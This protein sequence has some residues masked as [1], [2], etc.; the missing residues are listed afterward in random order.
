MVEH[1]K[2]IFDTDIGGDCDDVV[3]LDLLISAHQ[4]G[5]CDFLGVSCNSAVSEGAG[6]ARSVLKYRGMGNLPLSALPGWKT[7]DNCYGVIVSRTFPELSRMD[8]PFPAPLNML[9]KLVAENPGVALVS[10]GNLI[11]M[12]AL[13][14]SGP[15]EYSPLN[16]VELC[17]R[18]VSAFYVM[19]GCFVPE[20]EATGNP[21][22]RDT[23]FAECNIKQDV[24]ASVSFFKLAPCP[25]YLLPWE[26]GD[27]VISGKVLVKQGEN[28]PDGLSIIARGDLNGRSSWD[29]MTAMVAVWGH[30][31]WMRLSPAGHVTVDEEGVTWYQEKAD[32]QHYILYLDRAEEEIGQFIDQ[33]IAKIL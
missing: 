30:A 31:P 33:E 25:V 28:C 12:A 29:P 18:N 10:V 32:G 23:P 8:V 17:K 22:L 14:E 24:P 26:A 9:R 3:A 20:K 4:Q 5:L 6:C 2:I 7:R 11:N 13:L 19:G 1:K 15:D 27:K 21:N 16:G